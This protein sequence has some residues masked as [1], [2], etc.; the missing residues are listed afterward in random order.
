[1]TTMTMKP[2]TGRRKEAVAR[3]RLLPGTG[4]TNVNG[5]GAKDYLRRETLVLHAFQAGLSWAIVLKKREAFREAFD[6]FEA[7]RIARYRSPKVT[8]LRYET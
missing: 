2:L 1:M 8:S 7:A 4:Q 5:R 6:N 3:V